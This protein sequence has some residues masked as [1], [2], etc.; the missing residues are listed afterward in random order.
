M[1][2][3]N[4]K[5]IFGNEELSSLVKIFGL[6]YG[7]KYNASDGLT[8]LRYGKMMIMADQD[9]DGSHIKGLIINFIHYNW[10]ELLRTDF[11]EQFIT[12]IVKATKNGVQHSFFSLPEFEH[13]KCTTDN[14]NTFHVKY[15]KGL[16]TST[17]K[18]AREYFSD[19][20]RHQVDFSYSGRQCDD[21][22]VMAF[23]KNKADDRKQ[24]ISSWLQV[25]L[26]YCHKVSNISFLTKYLSFL[27]RLSLV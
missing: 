27:C 6:Q 9:Q 18:E 16:G 7:K 22:I 8:S 19:M 20:D 25:A 26:G 13:W 14:W 15:Y 11:I 12:P 2:E 3:A 4:H 17:A 5:Q 21:S 23:S 1:R 24:W 10:P